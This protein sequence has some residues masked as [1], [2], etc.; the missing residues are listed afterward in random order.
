MKWT[1]YMKKY[2]DEEVASA[3]GRNT[4]TKSESY[5]HTAAVKTIIGKETRN[6]TSVKSA[7]TD[8]A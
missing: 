7:S 4:A 1:D 3:R 2:S 6:V 8:R 5:V